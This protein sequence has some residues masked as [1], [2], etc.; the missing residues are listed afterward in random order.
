MM[1]L[2]ETNTKMENL[3]EERESFETK[4]DIRKI[5]NEKKELENK[6]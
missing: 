3:L 2:I 4:N 5:R 6:N 1:K